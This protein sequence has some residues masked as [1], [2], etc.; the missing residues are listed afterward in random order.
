MNKVWMDEACRRVNEVVYEAV[1]N[2]SFFGSEV[3]ILV[4]V[5]SWDSG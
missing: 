5:C 2:V 1:L 4:V 3:V